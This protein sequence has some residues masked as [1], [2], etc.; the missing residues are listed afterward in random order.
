MGGRIED[1]GGDEVI[2]LVR[3]IVAALVVLHV[4]LDRTTFRDAGLLPIAA[5]AT[6]L[7]VVSSIGALV[8]HLTMR[9]AA[10][11]GWV[12]ALAA[13]LDTVALVVVARVT[14]DA[15]PRASIA[16]CFVLWVPFSLA[17]LTPPITALLGTVGVVGAVLAAIATA[18]GPLH[19]LD[20]AWTSIGVPVIL[21]VVAGVLA[22]TVVHAMSRHAKGLGAQL[23]D[24]RSYTASLRDADD[25]KNT[26][27]AAVSHELRTPLTSILGFA[28]TVL[29]RPGISD[30]QRAE[31]L[32]TIVEEAEHLEGILAN[33][34]DLD[35]LTRGKSTLVVR[36]A[37]PA[38]VITSVVLRIHA[39]TGRTVRL[40]LE[41]GPAIPLDAAKIERVI[42]NLVSNAVKY[43]PAGADIDV[44]LRYDSHG[45]TVRVDDAGPGISRELRE[46]IFEPFRRGSDVGVAG[47]GIGLSL[48]DRFSRMHGGRAWLEERPGGGCRFQVYLPAACKISPVEGGGSADRAEA[49]SQCDEQPAS[50]VDVATDDAARLAG[51]AAAYA[52]TLLD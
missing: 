9:R 2:V 1:R 19:E 38:D 49:E 34:L 50:A 40:D 5:V 26:F 46:T 20:H 30:Q 3:G 33:L 13:V 16:W 17:V 12:I 28:M 8:A 31:M 48:V 6:S 4:I 52:D 21:V 11:R 14:V 43:T 27:L 10:S 25:L 18:S 45:V 39:R 36:E 42:E 32:R 37:A 22:V 29:D 23:A 7:I 41:E 15:D 44:R 24:E 51:G 47:T 35:R